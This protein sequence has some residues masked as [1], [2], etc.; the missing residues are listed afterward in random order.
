M[1]ASCTLFSI[2][3]GIAGAATS[4]LLEF[5]QMLYGLASLTEAR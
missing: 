5:G 2:L 3:Q 1:V 4:S